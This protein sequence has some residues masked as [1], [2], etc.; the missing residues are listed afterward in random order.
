MH[1]KQMGK[2]IKIG[3]NGCG[4]IGSQVARIA[5]DSS[6]I[7]IAAINTRDYSADYVAY[8]LMYDTA[9]GK[10]NGD[11]KVS[12]NEL[13]INGNKIKL[14]NEAS[15]CCI[16]WKSAGVDVVVESTGK[17][18]DM[19]NASKHLLGGAKK[20]IITA[21]SKDAPMYVAGANT[22]E[23]KGETVISHASCT[24]TALAPIAKVLHEKF[25]I[26]E[27]LMTTIHSVTASQQTVDG[28]SKKDWR[29]GR[30]AFNNIIPSSTGAAK[31]I[32]KIV[33]SLEG[34]ITGISMRIPVVNVSVIDLTVKFVQQ[35][36]LEKINEVLLKASQK[37]YKGI[38][39][40]STEELVS[41][42]LNGNKHSVIYDSKASLQLNPTFYKLIAWYDNEW[43]Y[44]KKVIELIRHMYN[45]DNS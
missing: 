39:E 19:E 30:A 28:A 40:Y 27:A 9:H 44:S 43:G 15:P 32:S 12:N 33:P 1:A 24:T 13:Y 35:T 23:Y 22:H 20:V 36:S 17:F 37:E 14:F 10:F 16:D 31:A 38:I 11:I 7:E 8:R 2:K 18:T 21:P 26:A 5:A 45:V 3:I 34:K 6:D 42:D 41:T 25:E 29:G 4:R